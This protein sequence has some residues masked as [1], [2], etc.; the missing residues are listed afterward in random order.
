[1]QSIFFIRHGESEANAAHVIAGQDPSPL[2]ELGRSQIQEAISWAK[3]QNM[4]FDV[5]ASSPIDRCAQTAQLLA[6]AFN[7]P[8]QKIVYSDDLVERGSGQFVG[9]PTDVYYESPEQIAVKEYGVEPLEELHA[10]AQ[11]VIQ[12]LAQ[13]YP[14][15]KVLLVSHSGIG[16]ML[17]IVVEGRDAS[18]FDKTVTIPNA[19]I[20]RLL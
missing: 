8:Q 13:A 3:Q 15:K 17:R 10:R 19:S 4:E 7:Y 18:E 12:W 1:M 6:E 14:D 2:T 16:K 9:Q 5:I 20:T 11:R